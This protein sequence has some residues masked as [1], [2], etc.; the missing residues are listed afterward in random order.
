MKTEDRKRRLVSGK[1]VAV[2]ATFCIPMMISTMAEAIPA[3]ARMT[4]AACSK[5]HSASFPRLNWTGER[6]MRNG[7]QLPK[8]AADM[9]TGLGAEEGASDKIE[10]SRLAIPKDIGQI[11][12]VRGKINLY[13]KDEKGGA[14]SIGS[15]GFF[16]IF[17]SGH[18]AP[19]IALWAEAETSTNSGETEVHNYMVNFTNL[20]GSSA[21]NI[22]AGGFTP[23][24]WTSWSDQK[25]AMD[26]NSTHPGA[27]RGKHHFTAV[28]K[29]K[30]LGTKTGIEYYGYND[31]FLWAIGGG[32]TGNNPKST[33]TINDLGN[34]QNFDKANPSND[35]DYWLVGRFDFMEGS[36]VSLLYMDY[37]DTNDVTSWTISGNY[38]ASRDL[39]FVAQYSQD[40]SG[41]GNVD[42]VTGWGVQGVWTFMPGWTGI[43]RYDTTDNGFTKDSEENQATVALAWTP[44]ENTKFTASYVSELDRA[45]TVNGQPA[46]DTDDNFALQLQFAF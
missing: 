19:N 23:T 43:A 6:F 1:F 44:W 34:G 14:H 40:D 29:G 30:G 20:F 35:I 17:A 15:P 22:R 18:L 32:D 4:G 7:F 9:E 13:D 46:A 33:S 24:E 25:R 27:Y 3:F 10:T 37:G 36:S 45:A 26:S 12:S 11:L 2:L 21:F 28:G 39:E 8:A 5:C 38:R 16:A 31:M 42:D 41:V